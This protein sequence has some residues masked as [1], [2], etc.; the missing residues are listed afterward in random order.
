[1]LNGNKTFGWLLKH[2]FFIYLFTCIAVF[3]RKLF[4]L[5]VFC[6]STTLLNL[7]I[8]S[9]TNL[10][11]HHCTHIVETLWQRGWII[12]INGFDDGVENDF[13][14]RECRERHFAEIPR[15]HRYIELR[16]IETSVHDSKAFESEVKYNLTESDLSTLLKLRN[17][18]EES[19]FDII[20]IDEKEPP[21]VFGPERRIVTELIIVDTHGFCRYLLYL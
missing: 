4:H 21:A 20:L 10:W 17:I 1:M 18:D 14:I 7:L 15:L 3:T 9:C 8:H 5:S 11:R 6:L 12:G 16:P 2:S 19:L 13:F